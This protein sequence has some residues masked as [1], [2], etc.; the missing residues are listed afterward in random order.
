MFRRNYVYYVLA[1]TGRDWFCWNRLDLLWLY[2]VVGVQQTMFSFSW[3]NY[4]WAKSSQCSTVFVHSP[5]HLHCVGEQRRSWPDCACAVWLE[6]LLLDYGKYLSLLCHTLT[7]IQ[8]NQEMPQSLG[9]TFSRKPKM[10]RWG[11]NNDK[12][13]A[14][15]ET[16]AR[17]KNYNRATVLEQSL[18][19]L[20]EW[21]RWLW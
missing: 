15:C 4:V 9:T 18:R 1:A 10:E 2:L 12:T 16:Y 7:K 5:R 21:W 19:K 17:T 20:L 11:T 13:K 3:H 6:P 8:D 14:T